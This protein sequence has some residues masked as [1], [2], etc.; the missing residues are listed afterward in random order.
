MN[1]IAKVELSLGDEN[2]NGKVDV[3]AHIS[4]FG[5]TLVNTTQ[6]IDLATAFRLLKPVR[7]LADTLRGAL[8]IK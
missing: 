1:D 6:D 7:G 2:D 8:G 5:M 4:L 3:S